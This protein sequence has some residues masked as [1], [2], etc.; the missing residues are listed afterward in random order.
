MCVCE[1]TKRAVHVITTIAL[2]WMWQVVSDHIQHILYNTCSEP[3][4]TL[5][6]RKDTFLIRTS[7]Q[8]QT[9]Q[10]RTTLSSVPMLSVCITCIIEAPLYWPVF[11]V[12]TYGEYLISGMLAP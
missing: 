5:D 3:L 4:D 7:Q 10:M 9:P 12:D 6:I 11:P 1:K 2:I 8:R